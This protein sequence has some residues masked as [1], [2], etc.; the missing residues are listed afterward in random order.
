MIQVNVNCLLLNNIISFFKKNFI[1]I[2]FFII[3]NCIY[4]YQIQVPLLV[5][6]LNSSLLT[7]TCLILA[8]S[9]YT[10]WIIYPII[11]L[12]FFDI[13]FLYQY[14]SLASLGIISSILET[15]PSEA[16][17]MLKNYSIGFLFLFVG[18]YIITSY[19]LIKELRNNN[20]KAYWFLIPLI[21]I[22]ITYRVVFNDEFSHVKQLLNSEKSK[23]DINLEIY[24]KICTYCPLINQDIYS[25]FIHYQEKDRLKDYSTTPKTL[26]KGINL[27]IEENKKSPKKIIVILGESSN[28]NYYS[29]YGYETAT[30][31]FLD[32]LAVL[33][34][35]YKYASI[36]PASITIDAIKQSLTFATPNNLDAFF[37]NKTVINL[38]NDAGYETVW[39]SN[40]D[41]MGLSDS[42]IACIA[43]NSNQKYFSSSITISDDFNLLPVFKKALNTDKNQFIVLHLQGSHAAYADRYDSNDLLIKH[44]DSM[45]ENYTRTIHHT[46]RFIQKVYDIVQEK[47]T[48]TCILYYSDHGECVGEG[49]GQ[50][51]RSKDQF[52]IPYIFMLHNSNLPIDSIT[53]KYIYNKSG[54]INSLSTIN[55]LAEIMGYNISDKYINK[56]IEES[57]YIYFSGHK[58]FVYTD[59]YN[60]R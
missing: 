34:K 57:K 17:S 6:F 36:S 13:F 8:R 33:N 10:M 51:N 45:I 44:E 31:P 2:S 52:E 53:D 3:L 1:T 18:T 60:L 49:H 41:K 43:E 47:D 46:D 29:L 9:K 30:T 5:G 59:Y 55:I 26:P 19:F 14:S 25:I 28:R 42:Y 40:Q 39:I 4:R 35:I 56:T 32:S 48:S 54:L 58:P 23:E 22:L 27:N 20:I 16:L 37:E 38:A 50:T 15:T 24:Q 21:C 12:F 11:F 7:L